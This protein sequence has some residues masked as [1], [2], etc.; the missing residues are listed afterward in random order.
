MR[1][2]LILPVFPVLLAGALAGCSSD[3]KHTATYNVT[4]SASS[5]PAANV[6][7]GIGTPVSMDIPSSK[8][9]G[10]IE[11]IG[12]AKD[13]SLTPAPKTIA[14]YAGSVAPGK[15]GN[16]VVLAHVSYNGVPDKFHDLRNTK[17]GDNISV[18]TSTGKTLTFV[19]TT[20]PTS[21]DKDDLTKDQRVWGATKDK[22]LVLATCDED[23]GWEDS[24]HHNNNTVVWAK[25]K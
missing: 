10:S 6:D 14:W 13:G 21:I 25:L 7:K 3:E 5:A 24:H 16:S 19:V 1:K 18:K 17:V 20:G 2:S 4:S 8:I 22:M 15:V 23:S 9:S 11:S 12:V